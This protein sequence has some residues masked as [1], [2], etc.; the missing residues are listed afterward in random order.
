MLQFVISNLSKKAHQSQFR[1][2]HRKA[3]ALSTQKTFQMP[4]I[5]A[6]YFI[7]K[8]N[9]HVHPEGGYY[10]ET[11]RSSEKILANA[12]PQRFAGDRSICTQIY[13]LL[14]GA[15][16]SSFHRIRSDETWHFYHGS[17]VQLIMIHPDGTL[18]EIILGASPESG[19][20]FQYTVPHG[21][22][23]ASRCM[24]ENNYSL[25]G[26]TVAPGFDFADFELATA[27][28]L[29]GTFPLLENTIRKYC[30]H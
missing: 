22:W 5:N 18:D 17:P 30:R 9:M 24:N 11:Y 25:T 1:R 16:F 4:Q 21:V 20:H 7:A 23:F 12:L 29:S 14:E 8:F 19:Q 3:T 15:V 26:C 28:G 2:L 10:T 27:D 13:F 6:A